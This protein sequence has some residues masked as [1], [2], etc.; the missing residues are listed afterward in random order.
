MGRLARLF[1]PKDRGFYDLFEAAADTALKAA[2]LLDRMLEEHPDH[3]ELPEQIRE[4]E[5][6][7]DRITHDLVLLL[8]T[9]HG[10][11]ID[12]EDIL[13]LSSALDDVTDLVEE[14]ADLFVLYRI[15]A[16]MVQAQELAHLLALACA[17]IATAMPMLR[18]SG[19][20]SAHAAE[21][22]RLENEGDRVSREAVASLFDA[23]I[24]PM[25]VIRWK[26]IFERLE[27]AIDATE[28]TANVLEGIRIKNG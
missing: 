7:G 11:P 14:V 8:N 25:V 12:R 21:I 17:Q 1:A 24:D 23:G 26:D 20:F 28:R 6:V 9:T 4:L 27:D 16:P 22:N 15:E 3:P 5:H 18:T 13:D 19:D 10:T 2:E